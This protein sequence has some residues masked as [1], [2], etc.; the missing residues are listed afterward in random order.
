L[1]GGNGEV[2]PLLSDLVI[3]ANGNHG[4]DGC[5]HGDEQRHQFQS[6]II[7]GDIEVAAEK[8]VGVVAEVEIQKVHHRE[9]EIVEDVGGGN[10]VTEFDGVEGG[11]VTFEKADVA[12]VQIA[13]TAADISV[14]LAGIEL[15]GVDPS[16]GFGCVFPNR[17]PFVQALGARDIG[18]LSGELFDC[19]GDC[20]CAAAT[21]YSVCRQMLLG[22]NVC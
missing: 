10:L 14:T 4:A 18:H 13:M 16:V 6:G 11:G 19:L 12:K 1:G 2:E 9:G 17:N 5:S 3:L 7:A 22:D 21:G 20:D 15:V 8:C